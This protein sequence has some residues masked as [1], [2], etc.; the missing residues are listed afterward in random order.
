MLH[1]DADE[2]A[3]EMD[4]VVAV[5]RGDEQECVCRDSNIGTTVPVSGVEG[6]VEWL[7]KLQYEGKRFTDVE[8]IYVTREVDD[9]TLNPK[10][11]DARSSNGGGRIARH[12]GHGENGRTI[13]AIA[14]LTAALALAFL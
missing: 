7:V 8:F 5:A 10:I 4:H 9:A 14:A 2:E 13:P 1:V 6:V 11:A 12:G 3:E